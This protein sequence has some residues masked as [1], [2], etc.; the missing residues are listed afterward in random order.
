M[1]EM[2]FEA[3]VR[4]KEH[5]EP[6]NKEVMRHNISRNK[7]IQTLVGVGIEQEPSS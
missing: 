5:R 3:T 4:Q 1:L 7:N 2:R 6:T